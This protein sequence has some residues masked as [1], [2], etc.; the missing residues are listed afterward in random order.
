MLPS[1]YVHF[2]CGAYFAL[3]PVV[4]ELEVTISSLFLT[5]VSDGTPQILKQSDPQ[6]VRLQ[7]DFEMPS[8]GLPAAEVVEWVGSQ[9]ECAVTR[10]NA[11]DIAWTALLKTLPSASAMLYLCSLAAPQNVD[12]PPHLREQCFLLMAPSEVFS[13]GHTLCLSPSVVSVL[14]TDVSAWIRDQRAVLAPSRGQE[15]A[16]QNCSLR[17][18]EGPWGE[19]TLGNSYSSSPLLLLKDSRNR[20]P[21]SLRLPHQFIL[22]MPSGWV[23]LWLQ[24]SEGKRPVLCVSRQNA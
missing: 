23:S 3:S 2:D 15:G 20:R 14:S 9:W 5:F 24:G 13:K 12:F 18:C 19:V 4:S 1:V 8:P 7:L 22:R 21:G 10:V 16:P 6:L 17:S 11:S